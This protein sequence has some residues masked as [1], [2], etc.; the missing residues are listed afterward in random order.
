MCGIAGWAFDGP[1]RYGAGDLRRMAETLRHRG[2]DG[3]GTF[4]DPESGVALA[5]TRLSIID[6]S[7]SGAQP[8][9]SDGGGVVLV[10]NGEVYNHV[11]LRTELESLGYRFRSRCDTEVVLRAFEAWGEKCV[12]RLHGMFAFAAWSARTRTLLLARDQM[13][14]KPLYFWLPPNRAGLVFAS[15]VK[16][17]LELP[18]FRAEVDEA[19]VQEFLEFGYAFSSNRTILKGVFKV[20]PGHT[21]KVT[22]GHVGEPVRYFRPEVEAAARLGGRE[23]L[24]EELH[25]VLTRVVAEQLVADVPVG[26]L[27]SGGVDS[28]IISALAARKATV[29][30]FTMAFA[31][32]DVDERPHARVVSRHIGSEHQ[33]VL[34]RPGDLT[35]GLEESARHLDDLF[36]DWGLITT[37][38]LYQRCRE[39]G[40]KVVI[41]GEGA[42]ELF[43]GY[44]SFRLAGPA[45]KNPSWMRLF[46]LYRHYA[47][48]RHGTRFR[49]F[50]TIMK[51]HLAETQGDLFGAVRLFETRNQLPNN[52]VMK[53]D[54]A[55]M[56]VSV[57]AR[58]PFLDPR[59]ATLAYRIPREYLMDGDREKALLRS[60]AERFGLLPPAV[61]WRPKYGASIAA[62]W[63]DHSALVRGYARRVILDESGWVD[64]LGLRHAMTAYFDT[65]RQGYPAPWAISIFRNLAWRLLLLSLWS[66]HYLRGADQP[67]VARVPA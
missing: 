21:M 5:S 56:S 26:L 7:A 6:L 9:R 46:Q 11:A 32:S 18:E 19:S 22:A 27:L 52:Y 49:A 31:G 13:G 42:D 41:V 39:Q 50:R 28:G 62:S 47:G 57:E 30:T 1:C 54:K 3:F 40:I 35:T 48:R 43:G 66:R 4:L 2:P 60:M 24:E 25:E 8:M 17:F 64:D 45:G 36:G 23:E 59:V 20:L 29:R 14:V 53:V 37:R 63:M 61:A 44:P 67:P 15:E 58:V 38:L 55:S 51:E 12:E 33:E 16:A 10:Y 34:I 65:G